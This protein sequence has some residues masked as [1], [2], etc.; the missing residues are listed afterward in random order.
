MDTLLFTPLIKRHV[1]G[2]RRLGELLGKRLGDHDDYAESWEI[3]DHGEDQSVVASGPL[4]GKSLRQLLDEFPRE[5]LGRDA[6]LAADGFPLLLKYLD[7]HRVLSVQVHP[8]DAYA[9]RMPVPDR[10][11]TE[12][13]YVL[14]AG[15]DSRIYAGLRPGVDAKQL[16]TAVAQGRCE[17]LLHAITPRV[18]EC[19]FIPAGTVHAL[20][21]GLVVAEIQQSSDTTF[22]LFDWNRVD[23]QGR[24]RDLHVAEALAVTDFARGPVTPQT[25]EIDPDGLQTLVRCHAFELRAAHWGNSG[26]SAAS[27]HTLPIDSPTRLGGDNRMRLITVVRGRVSIRQAETSQEDRPSITLGIGDSAILP[28]AG[29]PYSAVAESGPTTLLLAQLP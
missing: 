18:G 4:A 25:P 28:A 2:G 12:A 24:S 22:R 13:W 20:G 7:C 16:A 8:D 23:A 10:G 15:P 3:V 26:K 11:K 9:S 5:L 29:G 19:Y 14:D 27:D 17:E 21:E 6:T 1:W